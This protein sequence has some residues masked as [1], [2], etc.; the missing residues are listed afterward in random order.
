MRTHRLIA[1]IA[2][3]LVCLAAAAG[4]QT[5]KV[6]RI[7]FVA[8]GNY[9]QG[10]ASQNFADTIVRVLGQRGYVLGTNLQIEQRGAE[11]QY[12]RLPA[13]V[14]ELLAR[15]VDLI[16]TN[17]YPAAAAAKRATS[18]VPIVI[19][20][21]GDPVKT[22]L[23]ASLARPGGNITGLSD[24]AA[25]LAP[26]RLG[27]LREA[28]PTLRRVAMLWNASDL[29]MT[30]R[31]RASE[32]GAKALGVS[33][34][35][36]NYCL[37]ALIQKGLLKMRNFRNSKNKRAY[38]YVLTPRGMEE[39]LNVTLRF[40]RRKMEEYTA[41]STEIERLNRELVSNGRS[42]TDSTPAGAS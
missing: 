36:V 37:R 18:T 24:V 39:K 40:L 31:Y 11:M 14:A 28:V 23:V 1:P 12:E 16:V 33:V 13:L 21:A 10:S 6:Y 29:G 32:T 26:K 41:L 17:S 3:A 4:A 2:F 5:A 19:I 25:E 8:S 20:G 27:L 22:S 9:T 7:G 34:G 35:K 15:K 38:T 42:E 30:M